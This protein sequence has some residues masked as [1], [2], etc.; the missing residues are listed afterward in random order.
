MRKPIIGVIGSGDAA[1]STDVGMAFELGA[2]IAKEGW[3]LV[4][5]GRNVGVMDSVNK[6]AKSVGGLTVGILPGKDATELSD[7]VDIPIL[8]GMGSARN[9]I[10]VLTS[11]VVIACG[12]GGA[13]TA[14]EIAM[15]LKNKKDVILLN[16][17]AE[18][19]AFFGKIGGTRTHIAAT[20]E[21]AIEIAKQILNV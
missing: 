19:V 8:T 14:S 2:M 4:S 13:G 1:R 6:G 18:A 7:F 11:N 16:E 10:N 20:A 5:G 12:Q 17:S 21:E 15:A 9:Y 3:I